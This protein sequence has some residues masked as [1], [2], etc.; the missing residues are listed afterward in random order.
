V[1]AST[2]PAT[3]QTHPAPA[4]PPI[5]RIGVA[6]VFALLLVATACTAGAKTADGTA[7]TGPATTAP[8]APAAVPQVAEADTFNVGSVTDTQVDTT[9]VTKAFNGYPELPER[10]LP[11]TVF[12]PAEGEPSDE[13]VADGPPA[14][15]DGP[16]P[17]LVFSHGVSSSPLTYLLTLRTIAS[18]GYVVVAPT[19]PLGSKDTP[20]G[21]G[22]QDMDQQALDVGFL[23]DRYLAASDGTDGPL[24]GMIDADRI[25]VF[26]HSMGAVSTMGAGLQDCC[27]DD[28]IDAVAEWS[29]ILVPLGGSPGEVAE[30]AKDRPVLIVHGDLDTTV[31]H[32]HGES[33]YER[34]PGPKFLVTLVGE[35]HTPPFVVGLDSPAGSVATQ[36]TIGFFDRYL[37]DDP[38]GIDR[39]E[40]AVAAA[41]GKATL[42]ADEQ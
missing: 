10:T 8:E 36:A 35:A 6:A 30:R 37:K 23:I 26:G 12:Y 16:F 13:A 15:G 2:P 39:L 29:G 17:L 4:A 5:R 25:G 31:P 19:S 3:P 28:R 41:P 14:A 42:Q 21:A 38:E 27:L 24:A 34:V 9:R 1:T 40:A 22:I 33:V 11:V 7:A 20:G 18:A 32:V